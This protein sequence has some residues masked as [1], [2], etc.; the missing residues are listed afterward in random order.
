VGAAALYR[1]LATVPAPSR[2]AAPPPG[3]YPLGQ[4]QT[5]AYGVRSQ[6]DPATAVRVDI[7]PQWNLVITTTL[8]RVPGLRE[9]Q[10]LE[11]ALRAVERTYPY[12]PAGVF[13]LAAYGLPYFQRYIP[14]ALVE[15]HLPRMAD[16]H[17]APVLV[18]AIRFAGDPDFLLLERNEVVFHLRSD[19]LDHLHDVQRAL[20]ERS[21]VLAG[22]PASA[23]D[24]ADLFHVTSVRTGFVG[25]GLPR[26]LAE[27]A[28]MGIASQI[29]ADAP[30]FMGFTSTQHAG[31]ASEAA[32][33]FEGTP[34]AG[35]RPLTTALPGG[36][37]A[38]GTALHLSYLVEDLERWYEL[39]YDER[40][41]RMF[42]RDAVATSGQLTLPT[43]WI[44]PNTTQLDA[45]QRKVVGHNE[46]VQRG[47]RTAGGQALLLRADFN[48]LDDMDGTGATPGVHFL[49]F[50]AGSQIF[51]QS[52]VSM[53][54]ADV[55]GSR[56]V[57]A[58][59][60]GINAFVRATRRQNFLVPPRRHR[61]FP[62]L[63]L[64]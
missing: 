13:A 14:A 53:D 62:L 42:H 47:S 54:A 57:S 21:G 6:P 35:A 38:G 39:S 63:E 34:D 41:A 64:R 31:Q 56:Q 7:P 3:G 30:L 16:E 46:A 10:R 25:A 5:A 58:R 50:S 49:A 61:A 32:V 40:V 48:T 55:V 2:T 4:Y 45:E 8:A 44:H 11:A 1:A 26:R 12:S 33:S 37:F 52:R 22:Q 60:T 28:G 27:Q 9:Q 59:A 17:A 23:A 36:Y 24:L 15:A 29:P 51:H 43:Q 20:F 19:A 18:D